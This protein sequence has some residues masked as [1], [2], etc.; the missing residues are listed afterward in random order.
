[1][2]SLAIKNS[3]NLP[4][5]SNDGWETVPAKSSDNI[6]KGKRVKFSADG[7]YI[8]NKTEGIDDKTL[9]VIGVV[10][11]WTTWGDDGKAQHRITHPG[12]NHPFR[13]ELPDRDPSLW[14][15]SFDKP[16]D[17]WKDTRYVY[18]IDPR[19]A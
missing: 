3:D 13:D 6:I 14:K 12:E 2:N 7:H 8:A 5:V 11:A 4:V 17:P 9:V 19:S 10:T 1:M 15:V 16:A 18:L